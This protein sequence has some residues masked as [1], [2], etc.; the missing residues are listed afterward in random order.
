MKKITQTLLLLLVLIASVSSCKKSSDSTPAV[1]PAVAIIGKWKIV[2]AQSVFAGITEDELDD[3]EK[4]DV[5]EFFT[6]TKVVKS[7]GATKCDASELASETSTYNLSADGKTLVLDNETST[8]VEL[9]SSRLVLR[10]D[11]FGIVATI[12]F[13]KI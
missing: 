5:L 11:F 4:D 1:A 13:S 7:N 3:C 8:V 10:Q 2:S 12:T 6:G 9:S